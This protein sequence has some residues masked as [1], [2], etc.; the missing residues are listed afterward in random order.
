[1]IGYNV[2]SLCYMQNNVEDLK[3]KMLSKGSIKLKQPGN[4]VFISKI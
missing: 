2:T 4:L 3:Q 1:M